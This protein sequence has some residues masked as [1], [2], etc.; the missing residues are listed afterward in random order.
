MRIVVKEPRRDKENA[1]S[2]TDSG[3]EAFTVYLHAESDPHWRI[4]VCFFLCPCP[5]ENPCRPL[6]MFPQKLP[7]KAEY[8]GT[9]QH[10]NMNE[11]QLRC[12]AP[13]EKQR[14]DLPSE[15][16]QEQGKFEV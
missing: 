4:T 10:C 3:Q 16:L 6:L 9:S 8:F 15:V 1:V 7:Q 11:V 13:T 14:V 12:A 5:A 2:D